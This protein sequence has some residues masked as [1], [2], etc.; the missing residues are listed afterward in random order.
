MVTPRMNRPPSPSWH[1]QGPA[2]PLL[3]L[4]CANHLPCVS[5]R[6][7]EEMKTVNLLLSGGSLPSLWLMQLFW[8]SFPSLAICHKL[9]FQ[10]GRQWERIENSS[11]LVDYCHLLQSNN[12][13]AC[14]DVFFPFFLFLFFWV[15]ESWF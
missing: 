12:G 4:K 13:V 15:H 8:F 11:R 6:G 1:Q 2:S 5:P 14:L 10:R 9:P 7:C 3:I